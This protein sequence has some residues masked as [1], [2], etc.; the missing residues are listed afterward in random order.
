[1]LGIRFAGAFFRAQHLGR[2]ASKACSDGRIFCMRPHV[3]LHTA[4]WR[5]VGGRMKAL[6]RTHEGPHAAAWKSPLHRV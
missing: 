2:L 3:D 4:A 6:T 1:M 5:L